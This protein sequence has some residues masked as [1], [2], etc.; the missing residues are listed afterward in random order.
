MKA[1]IELKKIDAAFWSDVQYRMYSPLHEPRPLRSSSIGAPLS[2][3]EGGR[4]RI[5]R[6]SCRRIGGGRARRASAARARGTRRSF[7]CSVRDAGE[8]ERGADHVGRPRRGG[9]LFA[10]GAQEER[11]RKEQ[12]DARSVA[13]AHRRRAGSRPQRLVVD[14]HL[15]RVDFARRRSARIPIARGLIRRA[16]GLRS[17]H[18]ERAR[19]ERGAR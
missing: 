18:Y 1:L 15:A 14:A 2:S 8:R 7:R 10:N 19:D 6:D 4:Q 17:A 5:S 16:R 9:R 3:G 13:R 11:E 12:S